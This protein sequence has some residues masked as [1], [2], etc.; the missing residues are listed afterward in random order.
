MAPAALLP[1]A[2]P[3]NAVAIPH[4]PAFIPAAAANN[5][6]YLMP[7]PPS[8]GVVINQFFMGNAQ[9]RGPC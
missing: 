9:P 7:V 1:I 6:V 8:P 3:A 5:A 2:P 4:A